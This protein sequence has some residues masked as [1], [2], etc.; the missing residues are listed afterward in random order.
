MNTN[1]TK[2]AKNYLKSLIPDLWW[3]LLKPI[4]LLV[5]RPQQQFWPRFS[6]GAFG[7][8]ALA[9]QEFEFGLAKNGVFIS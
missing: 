5:V 1:S 6:V 4:G 3:Y 8:A 9:D 7:M 2:S